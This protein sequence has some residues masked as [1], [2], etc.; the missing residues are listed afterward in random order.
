MSGMLGSMAETE[1][2]YELTH[3]QTDSALEWGHKTI[4]LWRSEK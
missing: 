2:H 1:K 4:T 3:Q